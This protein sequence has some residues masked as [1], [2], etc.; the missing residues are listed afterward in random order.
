MRSTL[1]LTLYCFC[2]VGNFQSVRRVFFHHCERLSDER[3]VVCQEKGQKKLNRG[4]ERHEGKLR[5]ERKRWRQ[6]LVLGV[7]VWCMMWRGMK[8][9]GKHWT[10]LLCEH[11]SKLHGVQTSY[12][13]FLYVHYVHLWLWPCGASIPPLDI[14]SA[15]EAL[16]AD[17]K[18]RDPLM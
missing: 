15:R 13:D 16:W 18:R 2:R 1:I 6:K 5:R 7:L 12:I 4:E 14:K 3:V 8:G 17:I 11:M 10:E 9:F